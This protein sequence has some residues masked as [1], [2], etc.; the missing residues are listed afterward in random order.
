MKRESLRFVPLTVERACD[1]SKLFSDKQ[2]PNHD[3]DWVASWVMHA[4]HDSLIWELLRP[5]NEF[6]TTRKSVLCD[7]EEKDSW[8][9]I[10]DA[11]TNLI[12]GLVM[13]GVLEDGYKRIAVDVMIHPEEWDAGHNRVVR[14]MIFISA[15]RND[16]HEFYVIESAWDE[17]FPQLVQRTSQHEEVS[18]K[19]W[20]HESSPLIGQL[21][22]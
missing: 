17:S 1:T 11:Q 8:S 16:A 10:R 7:I 12:V 3:S 6:R 21:T 4:N 9:A 20:V 15:I 18:N 2:I 22:A 19:V 5:G 13:N 14:Q